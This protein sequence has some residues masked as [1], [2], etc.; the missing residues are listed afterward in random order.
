M[1]RSADAD[2]GRPAAR[3]AA[4]GPLVPRAGGRGAHG[5]R[6][7]AP[8]PGRRAA[9][10]H[11]ATSSRARAARRCLRPCRRRQLPPHLR[12]STPTTPTAEA[13]IDAVRADLFADVLALG[14]T[15]S[16]EHGTGVVKREL[17]GRTAR[18]TGRGGHAG[19]QAGP[20][21]AG[22]PQP[23]QGLRPTDG[24]AAAAGQYPR[25]VSTGSV[26]AREASVVAAQDAVAHLGRG[27]L[28]GA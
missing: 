17:P 19:H 18:R 6:R 3:G 13:R 8:Q 12:A 23:G 20:R 11:R 24:L 27:R 28:R 5:G 14:G 16:G 22:H 15:I 1:S 9:G 10:R 4:A 21:P 25:S 26:Q 2:R 7:R